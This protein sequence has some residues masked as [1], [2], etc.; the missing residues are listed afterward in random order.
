MIANAKKN[1]RLNSPQ[2]GQI[3][4]SSASDQI[5][6]LSLED[7]QLFAFDVGA[8]SF[9][10]RSEIISNAESLVRLG[11]ENRGVSLVRRK[12]GSATVLRLLGT[13]EA[14]QVW[15]FNS[16]VSSRTFRSL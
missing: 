14:E 4:T 13:G 16:A 5:S 9:G 8:E 6:Y 1:K 7:Q 2:S 12:D 10:R 3:L 11:F 15:Q